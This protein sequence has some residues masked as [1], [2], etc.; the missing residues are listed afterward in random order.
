[1]ADI[2]T[3]VSALSNTADPRFGQ[4]WSEFLLNAPRV[5]ALSDDMDHNKAQAILAAGHAR[6][7]SGGTPWSTSKAFKAL[8]DLTGVPLVSQDLQEYLRCFLFALAIL[9]EVDVPA[10]TLSDRASEAAAALAE[11]FGASDEGEEEEWQGEEGEAPAP[12]ILPWDEP[13][14]DM[15]PELA[16]IWKEVAEAGL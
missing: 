13:T 2:L 7:N 11:A 8:Y 10:Y 6:Q 16:F 9:W 1:M 12:V 3:F 5:R 14:V 4:A 15:R